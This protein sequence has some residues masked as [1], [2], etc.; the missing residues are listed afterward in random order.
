[1]P[2]GLHVI[3]PGR[4]L[5]VQNLYHLRLKQRLSTPFKC[6]ACITPLKLTQPLLMELAQVVYD[7]RRNR[8][9]TLTNNNS[10]SNGIDIT[11]PHTTQH[12][13]GKPQSVGQHRQHQS[14][15]AQPRK[16]PLYLL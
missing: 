1:M 9:H 8:I 3:P 10:A 15:R 14:S 11:N 5:V 6:T 4:D 13:D 2:T 7:R 16:E 12:R